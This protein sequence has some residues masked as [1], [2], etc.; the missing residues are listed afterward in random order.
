ML[1]AGCLVVVCLTLSADAQI[2]RTLTATF[3]VG[4]TTRPVCPIEH[5]FATDQPLDLSGAA[6]ET[7][8]WLRGFDL[9]PQ[10]FEYTLELLEDNPDDSVRLYRLVF[11]SAFNSPF[12]ENNVVPCEYYAP[13]QAHGKLESAIVLDIMAGNAVVP[14]GLARGLAERGVAALYMPMA[15][16]NARRPKDRAHVRWLEDRP[17]HITD[18]PRQTVMDVRRAKAILASRPGL[19]PQ[20]VSITGVSLGGIMTSIAA[21]VDGHFSRVVPILAGGDLA[22]LTFHAPETRRA[23]QQ[24]LD[25]GIDQ[26]KLGEMMAPVEPLHFASRIDPKR[27]LMINASRDEV[28]P[29]ECTMQL[30]QAIG[31]PELLWLP[32]GHYSA[33]WFMPTIKQTAIDFI[34]GEPVKQLEF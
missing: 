12:P 27:C 23:K 17:D 32:S 22:A 13:K 28:I 15:Y 21:G 19:D 5:V 31:K 29:H 26:Q 33:A 25:K 18:P 20:Q 1:R 4:A 11:P 2:A 8:R 9:K 34:K 7:L 30:W 3:T 10:R 24:L 6:G 16:Y 14:R